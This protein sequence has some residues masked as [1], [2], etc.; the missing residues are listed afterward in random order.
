MGGPPPE[1]FYQE[2]LIRETLNSVNGELMMADCALCDMNIIMG[3]YLLKGQEQDCDRMI[4][5]V[6]VGQARYFHG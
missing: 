2:E 5:A 4:S 1:G 6:Q 3:A